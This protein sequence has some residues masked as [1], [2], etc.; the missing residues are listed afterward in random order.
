MISMLMVMRPRA[1]APRLGSFPGPPP[2]TGGAERG[3]RVAF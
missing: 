1:M 3:T 2:G